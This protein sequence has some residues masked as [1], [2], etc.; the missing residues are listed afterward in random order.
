M[1]IQNF[2][3]ITTTSARKI[4]LTLV[5]EAF[6]SIQPDEV[7]KKN[8]NLN[9][10][11][12]NILDS[13][14]DLNNYEHVYL[15]GFGK[16]SAKNA[17][18][19]EDLL[20]E[21]L[22][23][24]YVIDTTRQDFKKINFTQGT[25][26]IISQENVDFTLRV[27][28]RFSKLTERDL[29]LV[30]VCGGGSAMF[31]HPHSVSLEQKIEIEKALLKSGADIIEMNKIRQH[32]SDVK[33]GGLAQILYPA[34]I[35]TLIFSDVPG[36]DITYIASGPTVKDDT[37]IEDALNLMKKYNISNVPR[38]AFIDNP[39]DDKYFEKVKNI[40][41]L[42]NLTALNAMNSKAL[43]L[44][45][46]SEIFSDHFQGDARSAGQ[47]LISECKPNSILLVGG[48]TTVHVTGNGK[49]GRN[50]EVVLGALQFL[51][52]Q[53]TIASFDSDG[54]DNCESAG[55]IG[56]FQTLEKAKNLNLSI[57]EYLKTN[58]SLDFFTK[59]GDA[60]STG[61]LPSNVSDLMIIYKK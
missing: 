7:F 8:V 48:E 34:T 52:N 29:V 30:V 41:V 60:I 35:T 37:K 57:E 51:G 11:S 10:N 49:G 43:E 44:D 1:I 59:T 4:V 2:D 45:I 39:Q 18:L 28:D 19:L 40:I 17:K 15:I 61:R 56:D 36:N 42:S 58:N 38:E 25:H 26:P 12:L 5:E 9:G 53:T 50:Q 31:E 14:Y 55:A 33:G 16:G 22:N 27:M 20:G 46:A 13:S 3:S 21:K 6:L 32:L 24:G 23:E 47:I 54:W